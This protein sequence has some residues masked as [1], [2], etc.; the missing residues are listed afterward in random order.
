MGPTA[1]GKTALAERLA[2]HFDAALLSA[3]AFQIYRG[4]DIGTA[5]PGRR[6]KYSFIDIREPDESFGVGE[7][8]GLAAAKLSEIYQ[9]SRNAIIVGGT[10][11]YIRALL[12]GYADMH[13]P[14]DPGIRSEIANDIERLGLDCVYDRL[15][16]IDPESAARVD[17]SNPR[18]VA[19]ALEK[20]MGNEQRISFELP[21]FTIIKLGLM[22]P[23]EALDRSIEERLSAM[24][25]RGFAKEVEDLI[26]GGLEESAP[27]MRA[28]GYRTMAQ[29]TRGEVSQE[30]AYESILAETRR[31][32]K[33][34][35][36]WLRKE[37]RLTCFAA[38]PGEDVLAEVLRMPQLN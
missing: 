19:R 37:P 15:L 29:S 34:Q 12:E 35:R 5:K 25:Q 11:L 14:P 31:Y 2:D 26:A 30:E 24:M 32:A 33:R 38:E 28:I 4:L 13:E 7:Y 6:E 17:S 3:D 9:E 36:T 18:R 27:A 20:A 21:P 22:P 23:K 16:Q 10:G 1:S 8:V